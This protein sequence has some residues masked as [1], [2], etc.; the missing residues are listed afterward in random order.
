MELWESQLDQLRARLRTVLWL[1]GLSWLFV[2]GTAGLLAISLFDWLF[3][4]DSPTWRLAAGLALLA[5][6]GVVG[7]RRL[8]RPL[9]T[10]FS[11]VDLALKIERRFPELKDRLSSS[12]AFYRSGFSPSFGSPE[13]QRTLQRQT[14][15]DLHR[16]DCEEVVDL[17]EM[18]RGAVWAIGLCCLSALLIAL[19]PADASLAMQRLLLPFSAAAWPRQ[20]DLQLLDEEFAPISIKADEP[21]HMAVGETVQLFVENR[22][23]ELPADVRLQYRRDEKPIVSQTL[24]RTTLHDPDHRAR[25]VAAIDLTAEGELLRFRVTGGDDETMPW[26]TV[27][28]FPPPALTQFQISLT[29]PAYSQR[30]ATKLP[31]GVAHLSGLL[32]SRIDIQAKANRPLRKA[33]L[34]VKE[35]EPIEATLAD[36]GLSFRVQFELTTPGISSYWFDLTDRQSF[37]NRHAPRYEIEGIADT[38]PEVAVTRPQYDQQVTPRANIPVRVSAKDDLGLTKLRLHYSLKDQPD[39]PHRELPLALD[40]NLPTQQAAEFHW[41]LEELGLSAGNQL[42]FFAEAVDAYNLGDAHIGQSALRTFTVVTP[43]DKQAELVNLQAELFESLEHVSQTQ[44]QLQEQTGDLLIQI[45]TAGRLAEHDFDLLKRLELDQR[46]LNSRLTHPTNGLETQTGQLLEQYRQNRLPEGKATA[47]LQTMQGELAA[48]RTQTL[49]GVE[50]QLA[51]ALKAVPTDRSFDQSQRMSLPEPS[52]QRIREALRET[53]AGQT[54]VLTSLRFLLAE[55][56]QWKNLRTLAL[57][58][59]EIIREQ[60]QI[61]EQTGQLV[62]QTFNRAL[63]KLS[64][65]EQADLARLANRQQNLSGRLEQFGSEAEQFAETLQRTQQ[66]LRDRIDDTIVRLKDQALPGRMREAADLLAKNRVGQSFDRQQDI[67]KQLHNLDQL[68]SNQSRL[69]QETIL[70]QLR[71]SEQKLADL[72]NRQRKLAERTNQQSQK[73]S[74]DPDRKMRNQTADEQQQLQ[75]ETGRSSRQLQRLQAADAARATQRAT[76]TDATLAATA[77]QRPRRPIGRPPAASRRRSAASPP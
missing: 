39:Q 15:A 10:S 42:V 6:V 57:D 27:R 73:P 36:D 35:L 8:L 18:K 41:N 77:A 45:E 66:S 67:A 60:Q 25:E 47:Q 9:Q 4:L 71:E 14:V 62:T 20:T 64:P 54:A 38:V 46:Q 5:V 40:D 31:P 58:L 75:I 11:D 34:R 21:W 32:G 2:A 23:G 49:P 7:W 65:Q 16:L 33:I 48:L 61:S 3:H 26:Y 17:T 76:R 52:R 37:Q 44:Q 69:D 13:L 70:Q 63:D 1:F 51:R 56:S 12:V 59:Q 53:S 22:R 72:E 19:R 30:P 24:R 28:I 68:L 43:S 50:Q 55:L 74:A 29:P